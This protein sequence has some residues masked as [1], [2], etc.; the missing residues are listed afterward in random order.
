MEV[1]KCSHCG[2]EQRIS[3]EPRVTAGKPYPYEKRL[4]VWR[5]ADEPD[6]D[7]REVVN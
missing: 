3:L 7:F 6:C 1:R 5:H 4:R 2:K